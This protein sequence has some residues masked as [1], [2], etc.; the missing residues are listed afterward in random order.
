MAWSERSGTSPA[1][2]DPRLLGTGVPWGTKGHA[3]RGDPHRERTLAVEFVSAANSKG[4]VADRERFPLREISRRTEMRPRSRTAGHSQIAAGSHR[5]PV[6]RWPNLSS[7][8]LEQACR[9]VA[10]WIARR[11]NA[12]ER[13]ASCPHEHMGPESIDSPASDMPENTTRPALVNRNAQ[14]VDRAPLH[15]HEFLLAKQRLS[16]REGTFTLR[17]FL[18]ALPER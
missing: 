17:S 3:F 12:P 4:P 13:L 14:T 1:T 8:R 16:C 11:A 7:T 10:T 9:T 18:I 15:S 2:A 5:R 6:P